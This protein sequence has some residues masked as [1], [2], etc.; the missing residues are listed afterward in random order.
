MFSRKAP[1][2]SRGEAAAVV[3]FM[4]AMT[5]WYAWPQIRNSLYPVIDIW[6][7]LFPG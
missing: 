6:R 3:L 5:A 7:A 2:P 4:A 1:D